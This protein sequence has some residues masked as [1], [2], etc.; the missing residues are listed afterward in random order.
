MR[1]YRRLLNILYKDE[2]TNQ[3]VRRKIRAAIEEYDEPNN[4]VS[5]EPR[6]NLGR[7]MLDRKLVE[8]LQSFY[9]WPTQRG[10]SVLVL[11]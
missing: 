6:Q 8:V 2:V 5:E 11:W 7:G 9:C 10:S 4:K 3:D 1:F